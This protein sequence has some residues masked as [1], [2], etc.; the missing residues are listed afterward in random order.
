MALDVAEG[1]WAAR[2]KAIKAGATYHHAFGLETWW[3]QNADTAGYP[4]TLS[5]QTFSY[6]GQDYPGRVFSGAGVVLWL[7][8]GAKVIGWA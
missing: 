1:G 4:L 8:T 5:E 6:Q 3:R 2:W 7:P